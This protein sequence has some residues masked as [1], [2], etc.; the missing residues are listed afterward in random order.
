MKKIILLAAIISITCSMFAC[1]VSADSGPIKIEV[2]NSCGSKD[3]PIKVTDSSGRPLEG[4]MVTVICRNI[5]TDS[6]STDNRGLFIYKG[7]NT[8]TGTNEI[9]AKKDNYGDAS[10][11]ITISPHCV[12]DTTTTVATTTSTTEEITT[13]RATTTTTATIPCNRDAICSTQSGENFKTCPE[14]CSG[15]KDGI[16]D[17][18]P[19]GIC[20]PDCNRGDDIDCFCKRDGVCEPPYESYD[21]CAEECRKGEKDGY[22]DTQKDGVCDP[23]CSKDADSDCGAIDYLS[24]LLP[25]GLIIV[26]FGAFFGL[27]LRRE[28]KKI[29]EEKGR[30]NLIES[31]KARLKNGEDPEVLKNE[32]IASGKDVKLLELAEKRIWT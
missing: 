11:T 20:D 18:Q 15:A 9:T 1:F 32:L 21:N 25:L 14:D 19:E 27:N 13:T 22:C 29:D 26:L 3:V 16:C 31:L 8:K 7:G 17:N 12:P 6:G 5:K 10:M 28:K 2:N 23:D 30:D 24:F 4:V